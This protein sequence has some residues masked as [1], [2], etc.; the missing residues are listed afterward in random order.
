MAR[1]LNPDGKASMRAFMPNMSLMYMQKRNILID[2]YGIMRN[3]GFQALETNE[4]G[5][6][7]SSDA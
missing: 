2:I 4:R 7:P 6:A 5:S 3:S 1:Q